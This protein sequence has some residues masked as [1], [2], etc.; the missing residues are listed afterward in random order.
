[1]TSMFPSRRSAV[2]PVTRPVSSCQ[3]RYAPRPPRSIP[4]TIDSPEYSSG[5]NSTWP[6]RSYSPVRFVRPSPI[7]SPNNSPPLRPAS[8][9]LPFAKLTSAK[10]STKSPKPA[11][12]HDDLIEMNSLTI[13]GNRTQLP[14]HI[15]KKTMAE[16][17]QERGEDW[18]YSSSEKMRQW[19]SGSQELGKDAKKIKQQDADV[20]KGLS[21]SLLVPGEKK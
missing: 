1:M 9:N 16:T 6:S 10:A 20:V 15:T 4:N 14:G 2:E 5:S 7:P 8:A 17:E 21:Q 12:D 3:M 19:L 13:A 18:T 11:D